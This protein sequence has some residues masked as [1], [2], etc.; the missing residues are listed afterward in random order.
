LHTTWFVVPTCLPTVVRGCRDCPSQRSAA[1]GRF[2]VNAHHKSL[3]AW[4]L[5]LCTACGTTSKLTVLERATV[6][7]VPPGLLDRLHLNDPALV[8]ELLKD[9]DLLRRN[10]VA[11]DW[12]GAWRLDA[13][14]PCLGSLPDGEGLDVEVRFG[15]RIP[16]RPT[17]L[18]A[19]GCGLTRGEVE[20]A[21]ADGT[22]V[23]ATRLTGTVSGDFA[24]VLKR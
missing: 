22:L 4:L 6:R 10:R 13:P 1:S 23:S 18:V 20:R 17:R 12:T 7:S 3:D 8:A 16:V 11:L 24:S 15:A 2:R 5:V 14:A 19:T 9:P 21:V